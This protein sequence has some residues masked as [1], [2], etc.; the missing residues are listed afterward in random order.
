MNRAEYLIP[1]IQSRIVLL[2]GDLLQ[3]SGLRIV[4][5]ANQFETHAD[6]I[7]PH[8]LVG[9]WLH[10]CR[11]RNIDVDVQIDRFCQSRRS[12]ART[13][14][15]LKPY[16]TLKF[17]IGTLCPIEGE[18]D[19][20]CL[21]AFCEPYNDRHVENVTIEQYICYWEQLWENLSHL[22]IARQEINVALP[23]GRCVM[24]GNF[25][26][27]TA[28]KLGVIVQT[29]CKQMQK[30][31]FCRE[32]RIVLFG[33]DVSNIDFAGWQQYLLPYISEM[34]M[35]PLTLSSTN[36]STTSSV[37]Q[38]KQIVEEP[39][40]GEDTFELFKSD[41]LDII[42]QLEL[43]EGKQHAQYGSGGNRVENFVV[44]VNIAELRH[45]LEEIEHQQE[46]HQYFGIARGKTYDKW[47]LLQVLGFLHGET[48]LMGRM[49]RKSMMCIGLGMPHAGEEDN[50][51]VRWS[52]LAPNFKALHKYVGQQAR[53]LEEE[54]PKIFSQLM[55]L[56]CDEIKR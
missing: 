36:P 47:R 44:H 10:Q 49:N 14:I 43:M 8:S 31:C 11:E 18:S 42:A 23:G 21:A 32:M 26:F 5:C 9:K 56:L 28:Q 2:E 54:K 34:S 37:V 6:V 33:E 20:Y 38:K 53:L 55:D 3:Q 15:A 39:M 24:V 48:N 29:F 16:R 4:H 35:L 27:T 46:L 45:I 52:H 51:P 17:L 30:T 7:S 41:M 13:D 12:L 1:G 19:S 40:G 50:L 25:S 22:P